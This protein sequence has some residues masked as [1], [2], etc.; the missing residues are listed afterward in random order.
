MLFRSDTIPVRTTQPCTSGASVSN[1]RRDDCAGETTVAAGTAFCVAADDRSPQECTCQL[2]RAFTGAALV[3]SARP[4]DS[5]GPVGGET[6]N[7]C[8][9]RT[10]GQLCTA[11]RATGYEGDSTGFMCGNPNAFSG[12]NLTG[13]AQ[14]C[15]SGEPEIG[16]AHV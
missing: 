6:T 16:R 7:E 2:N 14:L 3:C 8:V 5:V 10:L 1:E 9:G 13:V 11:S 12:T 15:A 4:W